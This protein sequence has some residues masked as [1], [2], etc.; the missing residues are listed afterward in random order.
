MS[1]E[2]RDGDLWLPVLHPSS[3]PVDSNG[4]EIVLS[5]APTPG[6]AEDIHAASRVFTWTARMPTL[7]TVTPGWG[8]PEGELRFVVRGTMGGAY[9]LAAEPFDPSAPPAPSDCSE[10]P[11]CGCMVAECFGEPSPEEGL[12]EELLC[13]PAVFPQPDD[14]CLEHIQ[15]AYTADGCGEVC[16]GFK[17][18]GQEGICELP[19][20]SALRD[21]LAMMGVDPCAC[22]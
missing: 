21:L 17:L 19:G 1:L 15:A 14:P 7:F 5:L 16:P 22:L 8:Q 20:C 4:P 9:E 12:W 13:A 2:R 10:N 3:L 6:Y 18:P 11:T